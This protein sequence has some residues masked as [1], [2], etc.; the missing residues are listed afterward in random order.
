[1]YR[2]R[3]AYRLRIDCVSLTCCLLTVYWLCIVCVL[4]I[5]CVLV[6]YLFPTCWPYPELFVSFF[7][8][9]CLCVSTVQ[10]HGGGV[11]YEMFQEKPLSDT[12]VSMDKHF[13]DLR[14][15]LDSDGNGREAVDR[16]RYGE[17]IDSTSEF[18]EEELT[19]DSLSTK[20]P[21]SPHPVLQ[22]IRDCYMKT[23]Q[24]ELVPSFVAGTPIED[25]S[26]FQ[27]HFEAVQ[28]YLFFKKVNQNLLSC[29]LHYSSLSA[30]GDIQYDWSGFMRESPDECVTI[31]TGLLQTV[32]AQLR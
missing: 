32:M 1:V 10:G 5:G 15:G 21:L 26:D 8:L 2:L 11:P 20:D 29:A 22:D 28:R 24:P 6:L 14:G 30:S 25:I 13:E 4:C 9:S 23:A 27:R 3:F 18:V 17:Y 16:G 12:L 7:I 31:R 19:Y